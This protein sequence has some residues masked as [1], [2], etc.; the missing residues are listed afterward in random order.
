VHDWEAS[1]SR[2][3]CGG[4]YE[5]VLFSPTVIVEGQPLVREEVSR[6]E[7]PRCGRHVYSVEIIE[8]LEADL[9]GQ[10]VRSS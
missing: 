10:H 7:C 9:R 2:C 6:G 5:D 3:P 8:L 4:R 1:I